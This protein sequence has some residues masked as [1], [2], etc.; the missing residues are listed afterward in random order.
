[1]RHVVWNRL[2]ENEQ[3]QILERPL[4][5]KNTAINNAVKDIINSI[6]TKGDA[7]LRALTE[8]FDHQKIEN[9]KVS[10]KDIDTASEKLEPHIKRALDVAYE[11]ITRFHQAQVIAPLHIETMQGVVCQQITRPIDHVGFYIPGGSAPL[12]STVLMLGIPAKIA[13]CK[14]ISLC[15][16]PPIADE[17]LYLAKKCNIDFV[18]Q[19][20]GAQAIAALAYGTE[21]VDRVD[22]I[23]GPGNAF[24]TEAK[25]QVSADHLSRVAIDMPAG[26]SELLIIADADANPDFVAADLL[27][28]AEHGPDSHVILVTPSEILANK[29]QQTIKAQLAQLSRSD[30]AKKSL[31]S[32]SVIITSD[33]DECIKISNNYAPEHLIINTK[34]ADVWLSKIDNAGSI[35]LGP[36]SPESAGDYAS[37]TNHVLPTY[38][39]TRSYSSLSVA[40]FS[41]RITAQ[42]LTYKGLEQLA[43]TIITMA[44]A[45]GL[46]G[47]RN[48]VTIRI[49]ALIEQN[50]K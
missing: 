20:G 31:S 13:G 10:S 24:V 48:A 33:I 39:F 12:A 50:E 5:T 9:I 16:P 49:N 18:Y 41:K 3:Q 32:S 30:I 21:S 44:N 34:N 40:D 46:D 25:R 36:W 6:K 42:T 4:L 27:S 26:P 37:G 28:Q 35:F 14:K 2:K 19:L 43:P 7:K 11:N 15:S 17:I 1:M 8:Q 38:G 45:E 47:H 29:V 22:K 23:F